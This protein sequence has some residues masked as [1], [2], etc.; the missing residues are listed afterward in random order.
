MSMSLEADLKFRSPSD[1]SKRITLGPYLSL[2]YFVV[3][4]AHE[5]YVE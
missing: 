4:R 3:T 2:L 5:H 1:S